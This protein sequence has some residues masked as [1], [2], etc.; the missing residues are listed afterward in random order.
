MVD[1]RGGGGGGNHINWMNS[2]CRDWTRPRGRQRSRGMVGEG[3][4]V[5]ARTVVVVVIVVVVSEFA[6]TSFVTID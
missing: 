3:Q 5:A 1:G 2:D 6:I 4:K